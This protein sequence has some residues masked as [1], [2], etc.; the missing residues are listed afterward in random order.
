MDYSS[1]HIAINA[2]MH[3]SAVSHAEKMMI[4]KSSW[5]TSRW[6]RAALHR[7]HSVQLVTPE[8]P[9]NT[10]VKVRVRNMATRR[11]LKDRGFKDV[12]IFRMRA[13]P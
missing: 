12:E 9:L 2:C 13:N 11:L 4:F 1:W 7:T 6:L 5:T 10:A 8:L 3:G